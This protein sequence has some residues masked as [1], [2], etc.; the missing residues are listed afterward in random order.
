MKFKNILISSDA[1]LDLQKGRDFFESIEIGLGDYFYDSMIVDI[2]S[3]KF[4]AGIHYKEFDFF[5]MN[6]K[7]FSHFI[8]Y[9]IKGDTVYIIAVLSMRKNPANIEINIQKDNQ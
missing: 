5:R 7:K 1:D 9:D 3:L 4:F 8:Y 6:S 2:E